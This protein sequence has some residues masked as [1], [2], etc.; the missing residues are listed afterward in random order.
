MPLRYP[1]P[2]DVAEMGAGAIAAGQ[3][4]A[5]DGVRTLAPPGELATQPIHLGHHATGEHRIADAEARQDGWHLAGEAK[6]VGQITHR[7]GSAQAL[8]GAAAMQ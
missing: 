6:R 1:P 2:D 7:H 4:V 5:G 8:G 3:P